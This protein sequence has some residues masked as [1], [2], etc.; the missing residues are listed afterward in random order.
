MISKLNFFVQYCNPFDLSEFENQSFYI[1]KK[2]KQTKQWSHLFP[3]ITNLIHDRNSTQNESFLK[4]FEF[5][6]K[7]LIEPALLP[8]TN[9]FWPSNDDL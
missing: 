1:K 7:T 2:S 6:W 5:Q 4:M 9:D 8:V 3:T